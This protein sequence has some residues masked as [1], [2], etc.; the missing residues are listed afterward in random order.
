MAVLLAITLGCFAVYSLIDPFVGLL[1][2]VA[3]DVFRPGELYPSLA[4]FHFERMLAIT[5]FASLLFHRGRLDWPPITRSCLYFWATMFAS[6]PLSVWRSDALLNA[7]EFGRLV[8]YHLLI[9]NLV[10]TERRFRWFLIAYALLMGWLAG[11]SLNAFHHGIHYH[12]TESVERAEALNNFGGNPN[13]LGTTMV[14]SLPLILL[15]WPKGGTVV[16][17][18]CLAIGAACVITVVYTGSRTSYLSLLFVVIVAALLRKHRMIYIP[19]AA[20]CM[21]LIWSLTPQSYQQRYLSIENRDRDESYQLRL[22]AWQAGWEMFKSNPITGIGVGE[23]SVAAGTQ[24]WPASG[25]RIWLNAHSLYFQALGE[26][27]L[28][29][30][31]VFAGFLVRFFLLNHDLSR[32]MEAYPDAPGWIRYFP[33]TCTIALLALLFE[34]YAGHDLYRSNWYMLA[35]LAGALQLMLAGRRSVVAP[36][37]KAMELAGEVT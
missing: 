21:L 23:F 29:G 27:G 30:T 19:A 32:Q 12:G 36:T 22:K 18:L 37:D 6:V 15:L 28:L 20:A 34:G 25:H 5:V 3:A 31:A 16:R 13:S 1:G 4:V 9:V 10:R 17:A 8:L 14:V 2:L 24:F 7:I 26:L 33:Y 35:G 11:S